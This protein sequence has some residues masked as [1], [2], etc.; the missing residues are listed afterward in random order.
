MP[1]S[2]VGTPVLHSYLQCTRAPFLPHPYQYMLSSRC[3][4]YLMV[5]WICI[6]LEISDAE[7]RFMYLFVIVCLLWRKAYSRPLLIGLFVFVLLLSYRNSLCFLEM[8]PSSDT[9]FTN[10]FSH[11]VGCLFI[12]LTGSFPVQKLSGLM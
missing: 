7:Y 12:L 3:E 4:V 6:S 8:N 10:I 2:I 11:S 1:F 5:P 9:W